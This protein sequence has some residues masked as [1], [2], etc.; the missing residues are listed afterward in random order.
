ML[1]QLR[2]NTLNLAWR[3]KYQQEETKCPLCSEEED[4]QHFLLYCPALQSIRNQ[5]PSLVQQPY[6]ENIIEIIL[7]FER[8][9]NKQVEIKNYILKLWKKRKSILKQQ[10]Q[11]QQ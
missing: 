7:L 8:K 6:P 4:T 5:F 1:F 2:T 9:Y 3:K 11:Q 10:Q